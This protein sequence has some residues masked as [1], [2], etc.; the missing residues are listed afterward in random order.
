MMNFKSL[1][2]LNPVLR[3]LPLI[4]ALNSCPNHPGRPAFF[5]VSRKSGKKQP[6]QTFLSKNKKNFSLILHPNWK[7]RATSSLLRF[8]MLRLFTFTRGLI[9]RC[10]GLSSA[11]KRSHRLFQRPRQKRYSCAMTDL[12]QVFSNL[13]TGSEKQSGKK[14][15]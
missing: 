3:R 11:E 10:K 5:P 2:E 15:R 12:R 4:F 13:L 7:K 8:S 1:R 14:R 9:Q 6:Y